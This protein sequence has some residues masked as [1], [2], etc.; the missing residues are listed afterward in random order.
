MSWPSGSRRRTRWSGHG[1]DPALSNFDL[2]VL[3]N[4]QS[5]MVRMTT[6]VSFFGLQ[7]PFKSHSLRVAG[8]DQNYLPDMLS[9][10]YRSDEIGNKEDAETEGTSWEQSGTDPVPL[11]VIPMTYTTRP[12]HDW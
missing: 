3:N 9:L 11:I 4:S 8:H 6:R 12:S 10:S 7:K 2:L 5:F 1:T